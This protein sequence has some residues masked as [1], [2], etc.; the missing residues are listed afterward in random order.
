M[1]MLEWKTGLKMVRTHRN[2]RRTPVYEPTASERSVFRK[3]NGQDFDLYREA[4]KVFERQ[5]VEYNSR[6][7]YVQRPFVRDTQAGNI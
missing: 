2:Y 3:L 5:R 7:P 1:D 6:T 4:Q